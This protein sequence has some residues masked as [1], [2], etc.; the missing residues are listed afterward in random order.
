M[1]RMATI[2]WSNIALIVLFAT[3][4]YCNIFHNEFLWDDRVLIQLNENLHDPAKTINFIRDFWAVDPVNTGSP[5]F[6]P[7]TALLYVMDYR[8]WGDQNPFGFHLTNVILLVAASI[9]VYLLLREITGSTPL[10]FFAA[11]LFG[12][13]PIHTENVAWIA[14]RTD[15]LMGLFYFLA[16]LFYVRFRNTSRRTFLYLSFG[17]FFCSLLSKEVAV[18]FPAVIILYDLCRFGLRPTLRSWKLYLSSAGL[19]VLYASLRYQ[20][21]GGNNFVFTRSILREF[22]AGSFFSPIMKWLYSMMYYTYLAFWPFVLKAR[23]TM[24]EVFHLVEA[25]TLTVILFYTA[26][27]AIG[28]FLYRY[29]RMGLFFYGFFFINLLLV[30]NL[31]AVRDGFAERFLYLS[32]ITACIAIPYLFEW[33]EE[34]T[35]VKHLFTVFMLLLMT[36]FMATTLERNTNWHD[37]ISLWEHEVRVNPLTPEAHELL[38]RAYED[39]GMNQAAFMGYS[40]AI[41][42]DSHEYGAF[43]ARG[44]L[45]LDVGDL[46]HAYQDFSQLVRINPYDHHSPYYLGHVLKLMGKYE[47]A[48]YYLRAAYQMKPQSAEYA[49]EYAEVQ[50][51]VAS[52]GSTPGSSQ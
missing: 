1:K 27:I 50:E 2:Q 49:Q 44:H 26:V 31:F 14:G 34:H 47:D 46:E 15:L 9:V 17:M 10:A 12:I 25:K 28:V 18:T 43:M 32:S 16:L 35:K 37:P 29:A 42:L 40:Q 23:Y 41:A 13:H 45:Y 8:I 6:R 51:L 11:L 52:E 48:L 30:S 4:A 33:L 36:L 3:L 19:I 20:A 7:L 39:A 38:G 5:Y 22:A 21:L 24:P